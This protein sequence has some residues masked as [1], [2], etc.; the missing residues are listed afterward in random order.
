MGRECYFEPTCVTLTVTIIAQCTYVGVNTQ[1]VGVH[2]WYKTREIV[3]FV[4]SFFRYPQQ[5]IMMHYN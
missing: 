5:L 4:R 2:K 3:L 1:V